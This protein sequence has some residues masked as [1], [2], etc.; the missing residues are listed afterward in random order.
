MIRISQHCSP[1]PVGSLRAE[2]FPNI[3]YFGKYPKLERSNRSTSLEQ[4][5]PPLHRRGSLFFLQR[6]VENSYPWL[7]LVDRITTAFI[8]DLRDPTPNSPRKPTCLKTW[9]STHQ[10]RGPK[11]PRPGAARDSLSSDAN[12]LYQAGWKSLLTQPSGG[13]A[14]DNPLS[15]EPPPPH[16]FFRYNTLII[17]PVP[18]SPINSCKVLTRNPCEP[19]LAKLVMQH[20]VSVKGK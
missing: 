7:S 6:S 2:I 9:I 19:P 1:S 14:K 16:R 3:C 12:S 11:L 17:P 10:L 13:I 18:P 4:S 20:N 5:C 15:A 8:F